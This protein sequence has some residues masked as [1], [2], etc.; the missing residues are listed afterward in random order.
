MYVALKAF[1]GGNFTYNYTG[2]ATNINR[3]FSVVNTVIAPATATATNQNN[4]NDQI[5]NTATNVGGRR[6][7]RS[8][9]VLSERITLMNYFKSIINANRFAI[10]RKRGQKQL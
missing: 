7:K 6:K 1:G 9:R 8:A 3:N 10:R 2:A 5:T 4:D